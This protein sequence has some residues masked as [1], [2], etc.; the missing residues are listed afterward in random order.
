MPR[1]SIAR[2]RSQL[3]RFYN[4]VNLLFS[5]LVGSKA[6]SLCRVFTNSTKSIYSVNAISRLIYLPIISNSIFTTVPFSIW[7]KI[8]HI[9][10][11][12][13]NGYLKRIIGRFHH[14]QAYA[15]NCHRSFIDCQIAFLAISLSNSYS[16]V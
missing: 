16:K 14:R 2:R 8:G 12:R 4:S 15:V 5:R 1:L 11:I 7:T 6:R 9:M 13:N 10:S 3:H